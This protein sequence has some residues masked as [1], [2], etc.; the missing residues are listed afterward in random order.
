MGDY[1]SKSQINS[2]IL[3]FGEQLGISIHLRVLQRVQLSRWYCCCNGL[4]INMI[5]ILGVFI[6]VHIG[7]VLPEQMVC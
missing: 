7:I 6:I 2:E 3:F 5:I 4:K 1:N